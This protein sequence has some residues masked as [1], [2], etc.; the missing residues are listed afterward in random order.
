MAG[1]NA[2]GGTPA[3]PLGQWGWAMFDWANQPYFTIVT[4]ALFAPY[5]VNGFIGD[6]V[7][8]QE[9]YSLALTISGLTIAVLSPALGAIADM[10]GRRKPWLFGCSV[11]FVPSV[12]YLWFA[13]P[14]AP[15]GVL[16]PMVAL[17]L[18]AIAMETAGVF[19][20]AMLPSVARG[21]HMGWLSGFAWGLGY[22]GGVA[23]LLLVEWFFVFPGQVDL[24]GVPPAPVFGLNPHAFEA[25][26]LTGPLSALW[27]TLFIIPLFVFTPDEPSRKIAIGK[28]VEQGLVTFWQTLQHLR[29]YGNLVRF[30]IGRMIYADGLGAVFSFGGIYAAA[31]FGWGSLELGVLGL[32][33]LVFA[34]F[35]SMVGG[36][37]DDQ[38]GSKR[39]IIIAVGLLILGAFGSASVRDDRIFFFVVT[40]SASDLA[41][42]DLPGLFASTSERLYVLFG[43]VMGLGMGPAQASSRTLLA[44]IAPPHMI[45]EFYGLYAFSGKATAFLAPALIG[46]ATGLFNDP[47]VSLL[48]IL[49]MLIVGLTIILPVREETTQPVLS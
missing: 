13:L 12:M 39:T 37:A 27:Y 36:W 8:G 24:P 3:G 29:S 10:M 46:I 6:A 1:K 26:R 32:I 31:I 11:I 9:L 48:V 22:F 20:N 28:A 44:R 15:H 5:F 42:N 40:V 34:G 23:A 49:I 41:A 47:R 4:T 25:E 43:C 30:L 14:G 19:N 7:R 33:M 38:I 45:T 17:I 21:D 2:L 35:G 16:G 18:A